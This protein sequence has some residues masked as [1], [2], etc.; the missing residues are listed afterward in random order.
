[1]VVT[2]NCHT[3]HDSR[4]LLARRPLWV[5]FRVLG[6]IEH[7]WFLHV[8]PSLQRGSTDT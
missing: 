1:M 2:C 6:K 4:R 7:V 5:S 8:L 3:V